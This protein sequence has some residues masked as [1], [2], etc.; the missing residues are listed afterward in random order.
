MPFNFTTMN[1][2][3]FLDWIDQHEKADETQF[4]LLIEQH[5]PI[6]GKICSLYKDA[7]EDRDNLFRAIVFQLYRS[8]ASGNDTLKPST[9]IYQVALSTAISGNILNSSKRFSNKTKQQN[10]AGINE[11]LMTAIRQLADDDK[12]IFL[13]YLE[14]LPYAEIAEITGIAETIAGVKLSRIKKK[15]QQQITVPREQ[16]IL[17]SIWR[18]IEPDL[19]TEAELRSMI[20][21]PGS[22]VFGILSNILTHPLAKSPAPNNDLKR[23]LEDQLGKIRSYARAAVTSRV[24]V[25]ACLLLLARF[26]ITNNVTMRWI[27]AGALLLL[28][29]HVVVL[30]LT[31]AKRVRQLKYTIDHLRTQR[32]IKKL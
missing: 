15:V 23:S 13:L 17:K 26:A 5:Q 1:E 22:P 8:A 7:N 27:M 9:W 18:N 21:E 10:P 19:K 6:I 12:A 3:Q 30:S 14:E 28:A 11:Q 25:A 20:N 24:I 29:I 2:A 16:Y 4:I 31:W 32:E